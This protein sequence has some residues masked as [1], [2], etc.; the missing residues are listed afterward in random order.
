MSG[1]LSLIRSRY[2]V[3][4]NESP[5]EQPTSYVPIS[6]RLGLPVDSPRFTSPSPTKRLNNNNSR[7]PLAFSLSDMASRSAQK[8]ESNSTPTVSSSRR[9]S[10]SSAND[11][12]SQTSQSTRSTMKSNKSN[13][14]SLNNF[15]SVSKDGQDVSLSGGVRSLSSGKSRRGRSPATSRKEEESIVSLKQFQHTIEQRLS[16]WVDVLQSRAAERQADFRECELLM[17]AAFRQM[18]N[19]LHGLD[20]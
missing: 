11:S 19:Y 2:E 15:L 7:T 8:A 13:R 12:A 10:P 9:P 5:S 6:S 16:E 3:A 4:L 20:S 14:V 18:N 1:D 17:Q